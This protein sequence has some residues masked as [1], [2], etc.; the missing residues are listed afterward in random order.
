MD[1][2]FVV[3]AAEVDADGFDAEAEAVGDFLVGEALGEEVEDFGFALGKMQFLAGDGLRLV[4]RF[5]DAAGDFGAHRG[6]AGADFGDGLAHF[7][8]GG[9]LEEVTAGAGFEG[10][11]DFVVVAVDGDHDDEELRELL[12]ELC[13]GLDAGDAGEVDIHEDDIGAKGGD[14]GEGLLAAA[15]DA[16]AAAL[17]SALDDA[18]QAGTNS[19]IV[20]HDGDAGHAGLCRNGGGEGKGKENGGAGAGVAVDAAGAAEAGK[21]IVDIAEAIALR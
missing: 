1:V 21:T 9:A 20:L 11:E 2:E 6:A 3:D 17:R 8:G 14:F 15:P 16:D 10:I 19:G 13:G 18:S 5:D 4:E 7:V 12:L